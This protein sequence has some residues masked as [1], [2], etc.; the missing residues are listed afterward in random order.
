MRWW[1][2]PS[3]RLPATAA[4]DQACAALPYYLDSYPLIVERSWHK[5]AALDQGRLRLGP[6]PGAKLSACTPSTKLP[7]ATRAWP[8]WP[9]HGTSG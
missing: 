8:G 7:A 5:L 6:M 4:T 9:R 3:T 2:M 1:A